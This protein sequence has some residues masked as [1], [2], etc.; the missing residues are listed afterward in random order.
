MN[1]LLFALRM[2]RQG[3]NLK[4]ATVGD[5]RVEVSHDGDERTV[6]VYG[7]GC[8]VPFVISDFTF[9]SPTLGGILVILSLMNLDQ[10]RGMIRFAPRGA[11]V[12]MYISDASLVVDTHGNI[13]VTVMADEVVSQFKYMVS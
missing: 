11:H 8:S 2:A 4:S 7:K 13:L 6:R 3:K 1:D 10:F 9:D 12:S 5:W